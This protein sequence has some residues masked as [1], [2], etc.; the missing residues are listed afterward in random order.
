METTC[1]TA[2]GVRAPPAWAA[3]LAALLVEINVARDAARAA[4]HKALAPSRQRSF[5][6]R[7][8]DLVAEGL[9]A[10]PLILGSSARACSASPSTWLSP[11]SGNT[12]SRPFATRTNLD[13]SFTNN[14]DERHLRSVKIHRKISSCFP[15][16]SRS[17]SPRRRPQLPV[18]HPQE[19]RRRPWCAHPSLHLRPVDA[20]S[21]TPD[22]VS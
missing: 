16:P 15:Q 14:P 13:V 21:R 11:P 5:R 9:A 1:H 4:G 8:D 19:R 12:A 22:T 18:H 3:E 20:A 17:D 6:S 7:Y 2:P 10:N